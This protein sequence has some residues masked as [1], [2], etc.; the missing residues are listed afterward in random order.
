VRGGGRRVGGDVVFK[1]VVMA[2]WGG[3]GKT[4]YCCRL[5]GTVGEGKEVVLGENEDSR[6]KREEREARVKITTSGPKSL[7]MAKKNYF[8]AKEARKGKKRR[9][10]ELPTSKKRRLRRNPCAGASLKTT[11]PTPLEVRTSVIY[12]RSPR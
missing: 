5:G 10:G 6:K 12:R 9:N 4:S 1:C 8:R 11:R 2:L 7:V 3:G